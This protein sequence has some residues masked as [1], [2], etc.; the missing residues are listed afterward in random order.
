MKFTQIIK[1]NRELQSILI[2]VNYKI[3]VLSNITIN[4]LKEILEL[5]LREESINADVTIGN[6]DA[7]VQD[8]SHF[9][10]SK[11][12]IIFW[13]AGNI[14]DGLNNNADLLSQD[15]MNA[16]SIHVEGEINLVLQNLKNTPLILINRFSSIIFET[17]SLRDRS[18]KQFCK[19]LNA[20]LEAQIG[21]NMVL[22]DL[23]GILARIG[24]HSSIDLR[25][26]QSSKSLY[27][28]KFLLE[29][30]KNVKPAFMAATG[31][32]KKV[33][34]LDC[35]NTLWSGILGE[36]G[37]ASILM[38]DLTL[39]GKAFR[40]VQ[41]IIRGLRKEGVLIVLCSKNNL[42]DVD[43]V[44]RDHP[45]MILQGDDI[46]AKRV[47]WQDKATNLSEL[48]TELNLG[49][50]SFVFVDDSEFELGLIQKELPQVKCVL[51]PQNFSEYPSVI[52]DL[53]R[54]FFTLSR[55][56]EDDRKTEMY[57]QES[58]RRDHSIQFNSIDEYLAS[59]NLMLTIL[60]DKKIPLSRVAQMTQK[61]NQFNLTTQR[62]TEAD[63]LRMLNDSDYLLS[64]FSTKDRYGDYGVTG[65][66]IIQKDINTPGRAVI[67]NFLM[68]CRV[69]GRNV[70]Y[71]FFDEIV[72]T[73][74]LRGISHLQAEYLTTSKNNQVERFYDNLGFDLISK[75][76]KSR[77]YQIRL[78]DYKRR[79][80]NYI[81][82]TQIH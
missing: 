72:H 50:D 11:A 80:I 73:L 27:S 56:M 79:N 19:R 10:E 53:K 65:M 17:D 70:E 54:D 3:A 76:D 74:R 46:A 52:R 43:K 63:I 58:K 1:R 24:I 12:V 75:S 34:A 55:T 9:P 38:S 81:N 32:T 33:L 36:D 2:G 47:N 78:C 30:A 69:I 51:V 13:E 57:Q 82:T 16:L 5:V 37:E 71:A 35:D 31:H 59:L 15:E 44:F 25:L 60:W 8:S 28:T 48:S 61:T 18:L 23:D 68:S 45:D 20:K 66:T 26:F 64:A 67:D 62:Y 6:Y 29:Y 14:V 49:L 39:K 40:E 77:R 4:P 22:V 7:I 42:S 41:T 21:Q